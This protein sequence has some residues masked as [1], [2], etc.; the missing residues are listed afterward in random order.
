MLYNCT[1]RHSLTRSVT[2]QFVSTPKQRV[3]FPHDGVLS[4][5]SFDFFGFSL[6]QFAEWFG[7]IIFLFFIFSSSTTF[8]SFLL[9]FLQMFAFVVAS[10]VHISF[11]RFSL[12]H[13]HVFLF[14]SSFVASFVFLSLLFSFR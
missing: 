10:N 7:S 5:S 2:I 9:F 8:T 4:T 3:P 1:N 14:F 12:F 13:F 6:F 11:I